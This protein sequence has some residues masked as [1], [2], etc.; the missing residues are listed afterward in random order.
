[1]RHRKPPGVATWFLNRF[2]SS[3]A[4]VGDMIEEYR[5]GRSR[6]WYWRQTSVAVLRTTVADVLSHPFVALRAFIL[7][8]TC[9]LCYQ[10][11]LHA[12]DILSKDLIWKLNPRLLYPEHFTLFTFSYLFLVLEVVAPCI[13][14]VMGARIVVRFHRAH[15]AVF[16]V[17]NAMLVVLVGALQLL[18]LVERNPHRYLPWFTSYVS[19]RV[20]LLG[21]FAVST[22]VAGLWKIK[23]RKPTQ[24]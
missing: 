3:E 20:E 4:L 21:L 7:M 16:A 23:S 12:F 2:S 10:Y 1:M 14:Y 19:F 13:G 15:Q 18:W 8:V 22:L 5:R 11:V 17:L 24:A 9:V 6:V